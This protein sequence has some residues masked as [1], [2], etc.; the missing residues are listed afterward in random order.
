MFNLSLNKLSKPWKIYTC[1]ACCSYPP[2]VRNLLDNGSY[3]ATFIFFS[4]WFVKHI[5]ELRSDTEIFRRNRRWLETN[6]S[7]HKIY[8]AILMQN[9]VVIDDIDL[10]SLNSASLTKNV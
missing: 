9:L 2:A 7:I 3:L 1:D 10:Q 6:V 4:L 8:S 5:K